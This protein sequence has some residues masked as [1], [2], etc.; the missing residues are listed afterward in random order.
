MHERSGGDLDPAMASTGTGVE[1]L[2]ETAFKASNFY[3]ECA[4]QRICTAYKLN[5][6]QDETLFDF[7]E[8]ECGSGTHD[9]TLLFI[10]SIV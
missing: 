4:N 10:M 6:A 7:S 1:D 3:I 9:D 8:L 5:A 2:C